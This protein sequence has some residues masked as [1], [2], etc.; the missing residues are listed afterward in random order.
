MAMTRS[1]KIMAMTSDSTSDSQWPIVIHDEPCREVTTWL[2]TAGR[3]WGGVHRAEWT[4]AAEMPKYLASEPCIASG[5]IE[6]ADCL[7]GKER[8]AAP[9][10]RAARRNAARKLSAAG[11][12]EL[13]LLL[14]VSACLWQNASV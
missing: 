2:R 12:E 7:T 9:E 10:R 1:W 4:D 11:G 8:K 13:P 3:R 5:V 14:S 6:N